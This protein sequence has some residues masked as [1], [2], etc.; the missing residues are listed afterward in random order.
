MNMFKT[1]DFKTPEAYIGHL[2]EPRRTEIA[3]IHELIRQ[4]APKLKP[5]I[6]LSMIGY[7]LM[8]Y[9]SKSGREGMWPP[10][11]LASQKNYIS[12]YTCATKEGRYLPEMYKASLGKVS[13][14]KSCMR[15]KKFEDI[16]IAALKE[17]IK[18]TQ[19]I[20]LSVGIFK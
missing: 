18:E 16:P 9:K 2:S 17:V 1:S 13:I 14:G 6:T 8:P 15:Y 4:T 7:G 12:I 10:L 19:K 11:A 20:S 5:N 3:Q